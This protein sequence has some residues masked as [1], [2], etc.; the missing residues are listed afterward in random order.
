MP[1]N[2]LAYI[3]CAHK[4]KDGHDGLLYLHRWPTGFQY[5]IFPDSHT[6][7]EWIGRILDE[8]QCNRFDRDIRLQNFANDIN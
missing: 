2:S 3:R 5:L 1:D 6:A 7:E 4:E 8:E